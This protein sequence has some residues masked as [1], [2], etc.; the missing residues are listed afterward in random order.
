MI[1]ATR[2]R[3]TSLSVPRFRLALWAVFLGTL[4]LSL[5]VLH[6]IAHAGVAATAAPSTVL[7]PGG[8]LGLLL[9]GHYLPAVGAA[10]VLGVGLLRAGGGSF[11]PWLNTKLGGYA[12]AYVTSYALYLGTAW[13]SGAPWDA[14]LLLLAFGAALTASGVLDHWRDVVAALTGSAPLPP[15]KISAVVLLVLM[16][17]AAGMA[18]LGASACDNPKVKAAEHALWDCTAP[19]RA[20]AVA[21]VTPAVISVIKAAASADGKLIDTSTVKSAITKANLFSEAGILLSCALASAVAILEGGEAPGT[22]VS[23]LSVSGAPA[24]RIDPAAVAK[25][26][27]EVSSTQLAGAHFQVTGGRVL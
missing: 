6:A 20:D 8:L 17:G 19:Q 3:L 5:V 26:W 13:Q 18:T 25:L 12:L 27:A 10:L 11:W 7:D 16:L 22:A 4:V 23:A 14:H 1:P 21:A 9:T 2:P 24:P 15:A